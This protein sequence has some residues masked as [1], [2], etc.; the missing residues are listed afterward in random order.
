MRE[1]DRVRFRPGTK[2]RL[3]LK[4][5]QDEPGVWQNFTALPEDCTYT[6]VV[7]S[8]HAHSVVTGGGCDYH[9]L[10]EG[11]QSIAKFIVRSTHAQPIE[12][13][14]ERV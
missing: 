5:F 13:L 4:E 1:G 12:T 11:D 6:M 9:L 3:W 8:R 10:A 2:G 7:L 14:L